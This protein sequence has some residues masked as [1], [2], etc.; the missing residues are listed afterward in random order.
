MFDY[1]AGTSTGAIVAVGLVA[2]LSPTDLEQLYLNHAAE[3]FDSRAISLGGLTGPQYRVGGLEKALQATLG[4]WTLAEARTPVLAMS[5]DLQARLPVM[6][7]SYGVNKNMAMWQAARASS[8]APTYFAPY[9]NLIDGGLVN[10]NPALTACIE[11]AKLY[12]C[13]VSDCLVLSLGCGATEEALAPSDAAGWGDI[14]WLK[15]V[16]S[17]AMDGAAD[18]VDLQLSDLLPAGQYLRLQCRLSGDI[19]KMDNVSGPNLTA[20][21][22]RGTQLVSSNLAA[23]DALVARL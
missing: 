20:L 5:Y 18:L 1:I 12:K 7:T 23:L 19:A 4:G 15:P 8:A 6:L 11:A 10:N 17:I 9:H 16:L 14:G 3:I 13:V 2:G 21:R 22:Q